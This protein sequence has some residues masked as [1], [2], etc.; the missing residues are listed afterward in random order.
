MISLDI[1][2]SLIRCIV[3]IN[4][5]HI[6]FELTHKSKQAVCTLQLNP[7]FDIYVKIHQIRVTHCKHTYTCVFVKFLILFDL[8]RSANVAKIKIRKYLECRSTILSEKLGRFILA[9]Q[10]NQTD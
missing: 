7:A 8:P 9:N 6:T 4:L 10:V 5:L 2:L 3:I 1:N